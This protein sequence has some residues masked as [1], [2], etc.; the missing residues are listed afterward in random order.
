M[1]NTAYQAAARLVEREAGA[2]FNGGR[3]RSARNMETGTQPLY[4][5]DTQP[6]LASRDL[7]DTARGAQDRHHVRTGE[8]VLIHEVTDQIRRA[9]WPARPLA[10]LIG[11]DQTRLRLEPSDIGWIIRLPQPINQ[12]A[13]ASELRIAVDQDQGC[14]HHTVS[15]SILSYSAWVPK[16]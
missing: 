5:R 11:G 4:H 13:G 8:A 2:F 15:A 14:I 7:T 6:L 1:P 10:L 9:R 16:P 12:R 3:R